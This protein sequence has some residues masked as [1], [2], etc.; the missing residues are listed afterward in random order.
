MLLCPESSLSGVEVGGGGNYLMPDQD[1]IILQPHSTRSG[2]LLLVRVFQ[3]AMPPTVGVTFN[4]SH[5]CLGYKSS[6]VENSVG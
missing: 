2:E 3:S 6:D 4:S 5:L 1:R